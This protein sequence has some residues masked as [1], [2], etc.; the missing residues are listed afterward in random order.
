MEL[1][2]LEAR[3]SIRNLVVRYNSNGDSARFDAVLELFAPDA[4]MELHDGVLYEG[5]EQIKTIFTGT[6]GRFADFGQS[7]GKPFYM[8]HSTTT[9]QIDLVDESHAMGRCYYSVIMPHG[10]DHWGRYIDKYERRDGTWLFTHRKVTMD[11]YVPDGFGA[12]NAV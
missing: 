1:W 7:T 9:H 6:K 5:I 11:G 12:A 10:I 8:R 4:V 3:E 2:E